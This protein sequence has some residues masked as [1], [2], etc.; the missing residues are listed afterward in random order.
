M[1]IGAMTAQMVNLQTTLSFSF[2][3][4]TFAMQEYIDQIFPMLLPLLFTLWMFYLLKKG[5]KSTYLLVVTIIFGL[6]G[7]LLGIF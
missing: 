7:A 1:V 6:G 5:K 3:E 2:E 4:T